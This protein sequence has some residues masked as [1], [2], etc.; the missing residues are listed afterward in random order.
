MKRV[1]AAFFLLLLS[2][3][4]FAANGLRIVSA[5]P[6]GET[7]TLAEANE[8]RVVFSE[9]MVVLGRIPN[10]VTAPFF[11]ITPAVKGTFRW[12]GTTTLI[13]TPDKPLPYASEYT[14]TIAKSAKSVAGHTLDQPYEWT[15]STPRVRLLRTDWYRRKSGAVVIGL[16]FNQP[17]DANKLLPD[18][19]LRTQEHTL[20]LPP[21]PAEAEAKKQ[22][23]IAAAASNDQPVLS[24]LATDYD[25]ERFPPSKDLVVLETKPGI[26]PDTWIHVTYTKGEQS[27][28]IE[29]EPTLFVSGLDCVAKCDPEQRNAV[30]FRSG[31]G[32]MFDEARKAITVTD[33]TD[34]AKEVALKPKQV[35]A[36]YDYPSW[37]YGLDELGYTITPGHKYRVRVAET[38]TAVDGQKL[39]YVHTATVEYW[40]KSAF[41][42]FGSGHGV[43]ETGGGSILPFHARNFRSVKQ[44]L[45]PLSIEQLMPTMRRLRES[46]F[47]VTPEGVTPT[48]RKL[49]I[50]RNR[51]A[52]IGLDLK[53]VIGDDNLGLAWAAIQPGEAMARSQVY[54]PSPVSTLVQ[55]TNLG[56][57]VK[58][59]PQNTII[60]VTRLDDARP[61]QGA[62]V[63]IRDRDNKIFWTGTTDA[64]GLAVAPNTDLRRK[65]EEPKTH[66]EE[67][68]GD[69]FSLGE[70]H[71]V[72]IAEKDGD[73]G[74][75][76]SDWNEGITPWEFNTNYNLAEARPQF[77][78]TVFVD[79]GVYKLGEE[80]HFKLIARAD[81]PSGMQLLAPGSK[82]DVILRDSQ[83]RELDKRTVEVNAWSSAEWTWRVPAEAPLGTYN[84]M[85]TSAQHRG[86]IQGE[87]LV[88]AY[89]RPDFR[90]D[91]TLDANS[92]VAGT[93][94]DGRISG[95]Y[96]FG[97]PM[98]G[99]KV[100]WNYSKLELLDVPQ[101]ITDRWPGERYAFLG[102][103]WEQGDLVRMQVEQKEETLNDK[104]ELRL[105]LPTQKDA[106]VPYEYR[107][108]GVVTDVTRQQIA[109]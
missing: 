26:P 40:H 32:V 31:A 75:V 68:E 107:L 96:L 109:G 39:G 77:R 38:L 101:K 66:E 4:V 89:R 49:D 105:S 74:Y 78:G 91:V 94:L 45:A 37:G 53:P 10:P 25:K 103:D 35:E 22:K 16:R 69:W 55:A 24:F 34:P 92:T 58:D 7:A 12:S 85:A 90:V 54:D 88:A 72:V 67:W 81:T 30:N 8:I 28:T 62:T 23:A 57:S 59:S 60:L 71:F 79:R 17:V 5:G 51:I 11:R 47:N 63:T 61:V 102:R 19:Q 76:G 93:K 14:V 87:I 1:V 48:T 108:E 41:V 100:R 65:K 9:P 43:W 18:L 3:S 29:L 64:N 33:I 86:P 82:V 50:P 95:R 73:V 56:I 21:L 46:G 36:E 106:G 84:L 15:F 42:S 2:T 52:A 70:L 44:W 99:A 104:G 83:A 27:Y 80:V 13:F 97:A 98:P 6:V 20:E